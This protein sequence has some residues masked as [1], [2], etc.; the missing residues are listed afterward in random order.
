METAEQTGETFVHPFD[1]R[2]VMSGQGSIFVEFNA[3]TRGAL[4][5]LIVPVSGAGMLSG[6]TVAAKAF[7]PGIKVFGVEPET[8]DDAYRS[9]IQGTI[10][11]HRNGVAPP[12]LAVCMA[13]VLTFSF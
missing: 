13:I 7:K 10:Q 9:K 8:A 2:F 1:N 5:G 11:P 12:T 4:D 6:I 3:Q